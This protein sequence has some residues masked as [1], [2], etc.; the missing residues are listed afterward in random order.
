MKIYIS[1]FECY[2][3]YEALKTL[4]ECQEVGSTIVELDLP[5]NEVKRY[6]AIQ[7]AYNKMQ[8][9]L[10]SLYDKAGGI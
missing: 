2:P 5:E 6:E 4:N 8:E 3:V 9:E 1:E 10:E 7:A